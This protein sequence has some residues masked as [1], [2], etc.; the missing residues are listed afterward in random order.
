MARA[1]EMGRLRVNHGTRLQ[2]WETG[3]AV[4]LGLKPQAVMRRAFGA[5][6]RINHGTRLQ[7]WETG[8]AGVLGLKPQAVMECAFGARH[9][10]GIDVNGTSLHWMMIRRVA[11]YQI[12]TSQSAAQRHSISA[13]G[14][15]HDSLGFQPQERYTHKQRERQRRVPSGGAISANGASHDSLGFQPQVMVITNHQERQRR[16]P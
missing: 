9:Q 12:P 15:F 4:V 7:R 14:V 11:R 16:V 10:C 13:N 5:R 3:R 8:R 6:L 1:G 2:R